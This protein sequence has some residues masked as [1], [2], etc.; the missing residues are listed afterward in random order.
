MSKL[1]IILEKSG[2]ELW[3]YIEDIPDFFPTTVGNTTQEIEANLRAILAEHKRTEGKNNEFFISLDPETVEFEFS[4]DV[5][6]F[7]ED[8][9]SLTINGIASIAGIN[10][11][12]LR[13]YVAG[14]KHPSPK[15]VQKIESALHELGNQLL[16][17]QL[18]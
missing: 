1:E 17:V 13:Q 4:Y 15:Q 14:A 2:E 11:S 9:S 6:G 8:F 12:L 5:S 10:K 18:R 3:G 16:R 7:F